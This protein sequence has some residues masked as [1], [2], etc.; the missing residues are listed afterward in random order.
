MQRLEAVNGSQL[1]FS[2][3]SPLSKR[4]LLR[5]KNSSRRVGTGNPEILKSETLTSPR[6]VAHFLRRVG[7]WVIANTHIYGNPRVGVRV[8]P[9]RRRES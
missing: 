9:E 6:G 5:F 7:V 1:Y 2:V 4:I 8:I 3:S